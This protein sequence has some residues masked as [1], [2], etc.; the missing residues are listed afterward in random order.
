MS[1]TL[2]VESALAESEL[3]YCL[4]K[5]LAWLRSRHVPDTAI[6][7]PTAR[8]IFGDTTFDS[9][10]VDT[11][12][13]LPCA[14]FE[15][16]RRMKDQ[17]S[18]RRALLCPV[19]DEFGELA[20]IASLD[21]KSGAIRLWVGRVAVLDQWRLSATKW[22]RLGEDLIVFGSALKWLRN[23]RRGVVVI[24]PARARWILEDA[25]PIVADSED[26]FWRLERALAGPPTLFL[27]KLA[28]AA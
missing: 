27:R 5:A 19:R 1:D 12:V 15:F 20:D 18:A 23:D 4:P 26:T 6:I 13:D 22:P 17:R 25:R 10:C 21:L 11:I 3:V 8:D 16:A 28:R 14:R 7:G 24:D 9:I 2:D